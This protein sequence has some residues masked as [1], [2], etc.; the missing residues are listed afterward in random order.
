LFTLVVDNF[1][2]KYVNKDNVNH[3]IKCLKQKYKLTKD[4]GGNLYCGI[5]LNWNCNNHTLDISMPGYIIKQLQK[6][7]HTI[8]TKPQLCQCT[9]QPR[10][11]GSIEQ[12]PLPLDTSPPL[13]DANIKHIQQVIG[14]ILYYA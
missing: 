1:G 3:L 12:C 14:S 10:Q 2:V 13:L 11:Y 4:W 8:P 9:P 6:Y 5:K 7:K